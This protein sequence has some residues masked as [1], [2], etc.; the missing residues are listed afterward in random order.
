MTKSA[1]LLL[2]VFSLAVASAA[3]VNLTLIQPT[4]VNGT[5]FK[6]GEAKLELKDN[7]AVLKQG[8][9]T[10]E[11]PVKI[12]ANGNKYQFTSVGY[13][14]GADHQIK[15]IFIGG[16]TKHIVFESPS[17]AGALAAGQK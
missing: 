10:A 7:K 16:T 6:P 14:E 4:V 8:K 11:V 12:E 15:E 13:K 2:S 3:N 17:D 5:Q 9:L 1:L